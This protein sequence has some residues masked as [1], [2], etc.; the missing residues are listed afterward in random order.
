[1]TDAGKFEV[2]RHGR[3]SSGDTHGHVW[4]I[5]QDWDYYHEQFYDEGPDLNEEGWAY[6][7][8]YGMEPDIAKHSS[9]TPT[10][11]SDREAVEKAE[12]SF[13]SVEWEMELR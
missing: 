11:L 1:M 7:A 8:V 5:R 12:A 6:Y 10:C 13:E 2:L 9:R 4:I 3:W